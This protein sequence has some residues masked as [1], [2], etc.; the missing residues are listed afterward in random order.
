MTAPDWMNKPQY[1]NRPAY[2]PPIP[3][4]YRRQGRGPF[5]PGRIVFFLILACVL[6]SC[7]AGI[8][9]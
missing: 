4:L 9:R 3:P 7:V 2:R 8:R 6:W 1:K 5:N